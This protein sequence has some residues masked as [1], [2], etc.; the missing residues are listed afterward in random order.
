MQRLVWGL[1]YGMVVSVISGCGNLPANTST[2][3]AANTCAVILPEN[4]TLVY[5]Y[6]GEC[7]NG[8]AHG[9]GKVIVEKTY[10]KS[11]E[12][13]IITYEGMFQ[14]G[15]LIG[16]G[17]ETENSGSFWYEGTLNDWNR[18]TGTVHYAKTAQQKERQIFLREGS[19]SSQPV[20]VT[21]DPLYY[22]QAINDSKAD[23]HN[24]EQKASSQSSEEA[25]SA[26]KAR[27][28]LG[29]IGVTGLF[30]KSFSMALIQTIANT[31][32]G[33]L[34]QTLDGLAQ[35]N[36]GSAPVVCDRTPKQGMAPPAP[37]M[38][39]DPGSGGE[40][41]LQYLQEHAQ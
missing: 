16:R 38:C 40:V 29:V 6:V 17:A 14:H 7:F 15:H 10:P 28:P 23:T 11:G 12:K 25:K 36:T 27:E 39:N 19:V 35:P 33:I 1:I 24:S 41:S 8:R 21:Q 18:W 34:T 31:G 22:S 2:S 32:Q 4:L 3:A 30:I 9:H 26:N 20:D 13:F 37:G 5:S